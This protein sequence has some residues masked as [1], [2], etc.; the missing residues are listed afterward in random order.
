MPYEESYRAAS[1]EDYAKV[2]AENFSLN[3]RVEQLLAM[4]EKLEA[5]M[6]TMSQNIEDLPKH[7]QPA[8][9]TDP[10]AENYQLKSKIASLQFQIEQ[11]QRGQDEV[12]EP[13]VPGA[14]ILLD[15]YALITGPRQAE[16]S[17]PVADYTKVTDI[18]HSLTGIRL[19]LEQGILFMVAI[20]LARL[21]TNIE[22]GQMH[23]DSL[24]DAAGYL[25]CLGM[26]SQDLDPWAP[27]YENGGQ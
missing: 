18:F 16:Y 27:Y 8:A 20:K 3:L 23:W 17:H 14:D 25:G 15:A 9:S 11:L 2:K 13:P 5:K 4:I 10:L 7:E 21:R 24:V 6:A 22:A 26:V 19:S 12:E 1:Q